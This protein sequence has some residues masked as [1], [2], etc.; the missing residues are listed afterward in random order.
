MI[1]ACFFGVVIVLSV[2]GENPLDWS[3]IVAGFKPDF[4]K[5]FRPADTFLPIL[6][7]VGSAGNGTREYW[8]AV[9]VDQ[10][11]HLFVTVPR[12]VNE[13]HLHLAHRE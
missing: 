10:Q 9:I 8:S 7:A 3:R 11:R 2:S 6:D 4:G 13:L 5:F 12:S 1:V